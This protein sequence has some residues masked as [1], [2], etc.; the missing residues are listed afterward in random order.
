MLSV[1]FSPQLEMFIWQYLNIR[2]ENK[3]TLQTTAEALNYFILNDIRY[4]A[5]CGI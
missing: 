2:E 4:P 1:F 5:I 3:K